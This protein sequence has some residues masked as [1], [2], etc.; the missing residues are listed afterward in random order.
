[1]AVLSKMARSSNAEEQKR[2]HRF[3]K[4]DRSKDTYWVL[5]VDMIQKSEFAERWEKDTPCIESFYK[6]E[7][8]FKERLETDL[9][10]KTTTAEAFTLCCLF[11][12]VAND[13]GYL[14]FLDGAC[15]KIALEYWTWATIWAL[16][17]SLI[18]I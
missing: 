9:G 7:E 4:R 2:S 17:L 1:M 16:Y 5:P 15:D 12:V 3:A 11:A 6:E 18:H 8:T 13:T 10:V 14:P